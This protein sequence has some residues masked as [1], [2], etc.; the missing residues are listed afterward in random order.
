MSESEHECES[1]WLLVLASGQH[2]VGCPSEESDGQRGHDENVAPGHHRAGP[3]PFNE[4]SIGII[5][6]KT[7]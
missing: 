5:A 4:R 6:C 2:W 1:G 7:V 3:W